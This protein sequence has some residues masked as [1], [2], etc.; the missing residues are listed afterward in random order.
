M[1]KSGLRRWR[2][3][4]ALF[5][6]LALLSACG[7]SGQGNSSLRY[8]SLEENS[9]RTSSENRIVIKGIAFVPANIEVETGTEVKWVNEDAVDHTVTSGIQREQGVPGVEEDKPASPDGMFDES[10][11]KTGDVFAFKFEESGTF[12]YYCDVHAGMTGEITVK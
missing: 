4:A 3:P 7:D 12:T 9:G 8:S 10:L 11:P 2:I 6:A 5:C 1:D